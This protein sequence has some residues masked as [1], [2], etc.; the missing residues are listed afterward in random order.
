MANPLF[1]REDKYLSVWYGKYYT[2]KYEWDTVLNRIYKTRECRIIRK[3]GIVWWN[4]DGCLCVGPYYTVQPYAEI[5]CA[6]NYD[7]IALR[8]YVEYICGLQ[9]CGEHVISFAHGRVA[10]PYLFCDS[11]GYIHIIPPIFGTRYDL[12]MYDERDPSIRLLIRRITEREFHHRG[13]IANYGYEAIK[14][15]DRKYQL[16][17]NTMCTETPSV[18]GSI[19]NVRMQGLA[20]IRGISLTIVCLCDIGF[21]KVIPME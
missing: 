14:I 7:S 9:W 11:R 13:Y 17:F 5:Q 2:I 15:S 6:D 16:K 20:S 19:Y 18:E 8:Y 10:Q 1:R 12:L 4:R 21:G 3:R